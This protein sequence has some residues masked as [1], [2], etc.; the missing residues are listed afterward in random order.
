MPP[1]KVNENQLLDRL[2]G[3]FRLH[4]YEGASLSR[5]AKATGLQRASLYFRF[6]GGKEEMAEAVLSKADDWFATHILAPLTQDGEPVKRV[7]K[8]AKRLGEFYGSGRQ[9]C[10]LD[11]LSLGD[12]TNALQ[13]HVQRSFAA[14]LD[15]MTAI[16]R[17]VGVKPATARRRAEDALMQI[18]GA[19]VFTRATGN[20]RPFERVL[21]S[22]PGL[23]TG[24][25]GA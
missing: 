5:I 17:E 20:T 23:L 1:S 8:M 25:H 11:T 2:T 9:S 3:V 6:P 13:R 7:R 15:A 24:S 18:Q 22:L 4:G 16:A 12:A 10:L 14:W 21:A 19:L